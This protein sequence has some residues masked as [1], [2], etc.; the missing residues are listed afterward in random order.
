[1]C[2]LVDLTTVDKLAVFN[3]DFRCFSNQ[4]VLFLAIKDAM[5]SSPQGA[6]QL[7]HK[8]GF[9]KGYPDFTLVFNRNQASIAY[10][11]QYIQLLPVAGYDVIVL[12]PLWGAASDSWIRMLQ[13][14]PWLYLVF[15]S[16]NTSTVPRSDII[17]CYFQP[18]MTSHCWFRQ[19]ALQVVSAC[20][21]WKGHPTLNLFAMVTIHLSCT[22]SDTI[23]FSC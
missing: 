3:I 16:N 1:M 8:C 5:A 14:R 9:L 2:V 4:K 20:E 19:G 10:R 13:G 6:L 15:N 21:F 22:V 18:E 12:L 23:R 11:S 7:I 17:R